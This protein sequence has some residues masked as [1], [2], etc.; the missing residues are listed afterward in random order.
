MALGFYFSPDSFSREQYDACI[1][2]LE[3]AGQGAPAGRLSHVA[4]ASGDGLHV[5]DVWES[6]ASFEAF[7]Q[8][9]M[10]IL[11]QVG[12]DPGPPHVSEVHNLIQ[13]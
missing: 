7:G 9:L 6:Q 10:P 5:F 12:V 8:T 2:L 11:G 4:F 1:K 13:G 3:D